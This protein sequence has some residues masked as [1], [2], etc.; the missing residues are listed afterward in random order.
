MVIEYGN[1]AILIIGITVGSEEFRFSHFL[2]ADDIV[3]IE[4][5]S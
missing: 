4:K 2:Y 3:F 5:W 1:E